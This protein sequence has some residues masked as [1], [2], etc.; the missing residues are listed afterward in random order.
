LDIFKIRQATITVLGAPSLVDQWV[1]LDMSQGTKRRCRHR[2]K[3]A[4][5]K[6][7][8]KLFLIFDILVRPCWVDVGNGYEE[9]NVAEIDGVRLDLHCLL[10]H[11]SEALQ[12]RFSNDESH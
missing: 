2:A 7:C 3:D 11:N 6:V 8:S 9:R 12:T 1:M 10:I 5:S 4:R